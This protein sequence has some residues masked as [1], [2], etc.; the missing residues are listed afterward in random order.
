MSNFDDHA[1]GWIN[2][3]A[4]HNSAMDGLVI[5]VSAWAVPILVLAVAL[6]GW[7]GDDRRANRHTLISAG[8]S[9]GLA[10]SINQLILLIVHRV[11]PYDA[12]VTHL[13]I[14][15]SKDPSFPSDHATA[16]AAIAAAFLFHLAPRRAALFGA[17]AILV[18]FSRVYIGT[19]YCG[20][21]LGGALTGLLGA[22]IVRYAYQP[23]TKLDRLVTGVL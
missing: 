20:D 10:L 12:G 16:T 18:G 6:Q 17:A 13:L 3:L 21:V 7:A 14:E 8:L 22:W 4:G 11:R 9:F 5:I 23:D 15:K 2:S 19:H 1:T